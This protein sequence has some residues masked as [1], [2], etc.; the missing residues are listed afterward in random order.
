MTFA[1]GAVGRVDVVVDWESPLNTIDMSGYEGRCDAVGRCGRIVMT[2]RVTGV[3]PLAGTFDA[4][5]LPPGEYT[6]RIDNLGP[7]EETVRYEV[8]LTSP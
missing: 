2:T 1:T 4:P 3:K 7:G 8:R 5:R 6:V